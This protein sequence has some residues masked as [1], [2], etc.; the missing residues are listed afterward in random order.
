[1]SDPHSLKMLKDRMTK[2]RNPDH[3]RKLAGH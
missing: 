2:A 1:M 3:T